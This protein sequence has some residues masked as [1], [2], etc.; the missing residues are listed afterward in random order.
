V[1]TLSY[2]LGKH[3]LKFGIDF[4]Q[5]FTP[6]DTIRELESIGFASKT[7]VQ[8][9]ISGSAG[10][11]SLASFAVGPVYRNFSAF[12]QDDWRATQKLS[13]SLGLRWELNP[14][15]T[16][17]HGH[18]PYTLDQ[19]T[20][21]STAQVAPAGTPLWKT[22]YRNFAPRVGVAY[23]LRQSAGWETVVRGGIGVFYDLGNTYASNGYL[24]VGI[25]LSRTITNVPFPLTAAQIALP[26]PSV[27]PPYNATVVAF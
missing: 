8:Q 5:L 14:P 25:G 17:A 18:L 15:P 26:P 20:N 16:D 7:Q 22:T 3:A 6:L 12:G 1:D 2:T 19:I 11:Q 10:L 4:R 27:S 23:Q 9:S 13:L 24:G 21:L